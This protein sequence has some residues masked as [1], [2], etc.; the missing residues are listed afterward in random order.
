[1]TPHATVSDF[2]AF[3][4]TEVFGHPILK[5]PIW[6]RFRSESLSRSQLRRFAV[7]YYQH[8]KRTRLYGAAVLARTP[9]EPIQAALTSVLWDEYGEGD[10]RHTHPAQFRR[11]LTALGSTPA[12]WDATADLRELEIYVD[13]HH[14]LC[15]DYSFW[16][17]LGVVTVAMELPIPVF[18]E[19]LI[20]G[21]RKGGLADDDLEFFIKHG[22]MDVHHASMLADAV[23]PHLESDAD[24]RDFRYGV[25]RSLD[26]RSVLMDGM[27]RVLSQSI[28]GNEVPV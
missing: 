28:D 21:F 3:L 16:V 4:R 1:M 23:I 9:I 17:G 7:H 25:L 5:H 27:G 14:R 10:P 8:V 19:S 26:A 18:Y 13:I 22:P 11:L 12:E 20:E 2:F 24:R 15:A 6:Q